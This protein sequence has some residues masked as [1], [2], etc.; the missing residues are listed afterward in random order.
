MQGS[1]SDEF[2]YCC[3]VGGGGICCGSGCCCCGC[4][5]S[6]SSGTS[7]RSISEAEELAPRLTSGSGPGV[8]V[9]TE[10]SFPAPDPGAEVSAAGLVLGGL[11][12]WVLSGRGGVGVLRGTRSVDPVVGTSRGAML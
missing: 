12:T 2:F 7:V 6:E 9:M 5:C 8:S 4:G 1:N 11:G 3:C 10:S